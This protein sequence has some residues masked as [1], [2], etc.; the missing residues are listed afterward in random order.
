MV[1]QIVFIEQNKPDSD[2]YI[3]YKISING[4]KKTIYEYDKN[5]N[6]IF[7][8]LYENGKFILGYRPSL[9]S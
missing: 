3:K 5:N 7:V 8:K 9:F 6:I 1:N 2:N 4:N